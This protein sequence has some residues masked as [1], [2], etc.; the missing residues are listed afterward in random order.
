[1]E[2]PTRSLIKGISWQVVGLITMT[3]LAYAMTGDVA[4][5]GSIAV[6]SAVTGL[7][8][9]FIHERVWAR[10]RWGRLQR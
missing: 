7:V 3:A 9:F 4:A 8:C 10:I 6:L 5:S 1:M 2:T